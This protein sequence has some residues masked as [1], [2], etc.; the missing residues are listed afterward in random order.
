MRPSVQAVGTG[1]A[2]ECAGDG[3]SETE[4]VAEAEATIGETHRDERLSPEF[5]ESVVTLLD[6]KQIGG[7]RALIDALHPADIADLF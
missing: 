4:T 3:M 1:Q 2:G 6:E 7:V 5:V